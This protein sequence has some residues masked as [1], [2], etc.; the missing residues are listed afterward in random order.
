MSRRACSPGHRVQAT[1]GTVQEFS[2]P[3]ATAST[4]GVTL[5]ADGNLWFTEHG[6]MGGLH[7]KPIVRVKPDGTA[8]EFAADPGATPNQITAGPNGNVWFS[9]PP[10]SVGEMTPAGVFTLHGGIGITGDPRGI[11]MGPDGHIYVIVAD[12]AQPKIVEVLPNGTAAPNSPYNIPDIAANPQE[13]A[14]GP[15]GNMWFTELNTDKV[16]VLNLHVTPHTIVEKKITLIA[17]PLAKAAPRGIVAGPDGNIWF[18]ETGGGASERLG[19]ITPDL[20]TNAT[21]YGETNILT[22]GAT[23]PEGIAVGQDN[24]LYFVAFNGSQV[25]QALTAAPTLTQFKQGITPELRPALH[26]QGPGREHVV[27]RGVR[28]QVRP[29]HRRPAADPDDADDPDHSHDADD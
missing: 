9:D 4:Y 23:D 25:I 3:T 13:I 28:E 29:D 27:Q 17:D 16:G 2:L 8:E 6:L 15:D 7:P 5:G 26:R 14:V 22:D 18:T 12:G 11:A 1:T 24:A 19:H 21:N 10:N 20:T